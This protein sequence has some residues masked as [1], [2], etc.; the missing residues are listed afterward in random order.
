MKFYKLALM[1]AASFLCHDLLLSDSCTLNAQET[2]ELKNIWVGKTRDESQKDAAPKNKLITDAKDWEVLWE[3]WQPDLPLPEVNF[4]NDL[5]IVF[6]VAG[7]NQV[8]VN[9]LTLKDGN[10][11][12][13]AGSSR[14][15]GPGF[16]FAF[17][18]VERAEIKTVMGNE[19][20]A[21]QSATSPETG[22]ERVWKSVTVNTSGG[23][24]GLMQS[25]KVT[26]D[27][28]ILVSSL[29]DGSKTGERQIDKEL[30]TKLNEHLSQTDWSSV[31]EEGEADQPI[32]DNMEYE[33]FV[34]FEKRKFAFTYNS[35]TAFQQESIKRLLTIISG[36]DPD[37]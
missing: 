25:E 29:R 4:N 23:I 19:V 36:R 34:E 15:G 33:I 10:L 28:K 2:V 13:L 27:G 31:P 8:M 22:D 3:K 30:V 9:K 7:P 1:L 6:Q 24:A 37:K 21:P 26:P 32:A 5:V 35:I 16:G 17:I 20:P 12:V 11:S 14:M 18:Q